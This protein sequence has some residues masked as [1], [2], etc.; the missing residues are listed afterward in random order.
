MQGSLRGNKGPRYRPAVD[1]ST[2]PLAGCSATCTSIPPRR[3]SRASP[4]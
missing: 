4:S 3:T 2:W 1:E